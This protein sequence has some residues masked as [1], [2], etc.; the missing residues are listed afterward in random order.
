MAVYPVAP[1]SPDYSST[2]ATKYIPS[3]Y[4]AL[5]VKK[6]YPQTIFGKISQTDYEG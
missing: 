6:F 2:G 3:I 1:G 4:S 5:L